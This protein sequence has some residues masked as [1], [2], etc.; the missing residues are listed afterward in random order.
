MLDHVEI[1][2]RFLELD[3]HPTMLEETFDGWLAWPIIKERLWL[4]CFRAPDAKPPRPRDSLARFKLGLSQIIRALC[5]RNDADLALFYEPREV[6]LANG[7]ALHPHL[8][9]IGCSDR[10]RPILHYRYD[11][12]AVAERLSGPLLFDHH[13]IGAVAAAGAAAMARAPAIQRTTQALSGPIAALLPEI[14]RA[15]AAALVSNQLA[16][17]RLTS[18]FMKRLLR[19]WRVRS[20]VVL[21]AIAKIPEIAAAKSLGLPV[22]EVQHG[23]FSTREPPYS[24]LARHRALPCQLPLPDRLLVFGPLWSKQLRRAGYW[25][26]DE[27]VEVPNPILAAYRGLLAVRTPRPSSPLRLLFSAQGYVKDAAIR[28]LDEILARQRLDG[29]TRFHLRIKM[30]PLEREHPVEYLA[31]ARK[32]PESCSV[33]AADSEAFA[34]MIEADGVVGYTSLMLLEA[35]GLGIPVI[36]LRGGAASAGF[37]A[38]FDVEELSDIIPEVSSAEDF[39][40]IVAEWCDASCYRKQKEE[41]ARSAARIYTLDGVT[42]EKIIGNA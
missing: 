39:L 29:T 41:V 37:C 3:V 8:G 25:R 24:W 16:R 10:G 31:L 32:Y 35:V 4:A 38:T 23:M 34:E 28:L 30:H 2:S 40:S 22:T 26:D 1:N 7:V 33:A 9:Q 5:A 36:G 19:T 20:V 42:V 11:W 6:I 12:R 21:D 18:W 15:S 27:V 17:F 14:P 13:G